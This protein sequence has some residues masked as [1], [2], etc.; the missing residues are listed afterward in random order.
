MIPS[1]PLLAGV[2]TLAGLLQAAEYHVATHGQDSQSGSPDAPLR[3]IQRAADLAQPG[4]TITV[5]QGV[6]RERVDPPRGGASD[7]NR[8]VYQAAPGE[9]VVITGAEPLKGWEKVSGDTWKLV[10][11]SSYFGDF[12]PFRH[13]IEGEW[14]APTGRHAGSVYVNGEWL[15]ES[16]LLEPVLKP[17]GKSPLW[18]AEV[19]GDTKD[20]GKH[21]FA[22]RSFTMAGQ[23]RAASSFARKHGEV[24][25]TPE[26]DCIGWTRPG[27]WVAY[28]G[29]N[30]SKEQTVAVEAGA[31][32]DGG[33]IE[34]HACLGTPEAEFL[35]SVTITG[36]SGWQ[37]WRS[38]SAPIKAS[39]FAGNRTL[40]MVFRHG[41]QKSVAGDN[42]T[43]WA[44]FPG[45]N[46]N[47]A[48]VEISKRQSVFYPSRTGIHYIT[49]R[50]FEL[51]RA[52]TPWGGAMSEQAGLIG[53]HWSKGWII[54][55]NHI[56]HSM[57][58][59]VA[60]GRYELPAGELP[61]A[62]A[63]GFMKSMELALRDG[64]SK[65]KVGSHVVRSNHIH[66]CEK[67]AIHGSLG[68]CFSVIAGNDIHDIART[69]WVAGPDTGG[70]KFLGGV[71]MVIRDNHIYR[72]GSVA[73]IWLD[74]SAQGAQ[75][76]GNL[77][78]DNTGHGDIFLEMQHGPL[79]VANNLLLSLRSFSINSEGTAL[80]HNLIAGEVN[81]FSDPR[82]TPF[83]PPHS[84]AIAGLYTAC[85]GDHRLINN[86]LLKDGLKK[87]KLPDAVAGNIA[88][89]TAQPRLM[90]KS[91]GWY[92]TFHADP[93]WRSTARCRPVSTASLGKAVISKCACENPDGTPIWITTDY[94]DKKRDIENPFPGPL[95]IAQ[96]GT[97]TIK[98]WPKP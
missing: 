17:V 30:L 75:V 61:P 59:G 20:D 52:A 97:Q 34:F 13:K 87:R 56:H 21:L 18:Y 31:L 60:L 1:A 77:L 9:N 39:G 78:H 2:L 82:E 43:I 6:Y 10:V 85:G 71:D 72:C 63:P 81:V 62:T 24:R 50:G 45:V 66:H 25:P 74:W 95:E 36:T 14:C 40:Y 89:H 27:D 19:G 73:G 8:I 67:N 51:C 48:N 80:A 68:A 4:D 16:L 96:G 91:D 26:K 65:E 37:N 76:T 15:A 88:T 93:T 44:Q 55:S 83:H 3:T 29:F 69:G 11:P 54:E 94:L 35:G 90:Q 12:N 38:F 53:T 28:E 46:P 84:V 33:V 42:T 70:I 47:E 92:L 49:V 98:V 57:C 5:H 23:T 86:L 32:A 7:E 22:I 64:W 58:K 79:L 41:A